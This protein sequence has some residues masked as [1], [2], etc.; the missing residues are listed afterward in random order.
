MSVTLEQA[1]VK[2]QQ[3]ATEPSPRPKVSIIILNWNTR[4][5]TLECLRSLKQTLG[6]FP[7]QLI[8]VDNDSTDGSAEAIARDHP[9]VRLVRSP[10]NVGFA[11]GN[12]L[13][14]P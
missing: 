6:D 3:K 11:C 8:A 7:A 1:S 9:D 4:E 10:K 13:A 14:L 5:L 12:N 2:L